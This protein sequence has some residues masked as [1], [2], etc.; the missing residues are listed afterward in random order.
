MEGL[1]LSVEAGWAVGLLLAVT[2]VAAFAVAS[3]VLSHALP[4]PGRVA[5]VLAI[6]WFLAEPVS[7][8]LTLEELL[9]AGVTNAVI[10]GALG[11][12]TGALFHMFATAGGIIDFVSGLAIAQVL[13]PNQGTRASVF[14]R[15]FGLSGLAMFYVTGGLQLVAG[16]LTLSVRALPLDGSISANP[17]L[18]QL[19]ADHTG[20]LLLAATELALPVL[21]AL[22]LVEVVLGIASRFAPQANVFL[23][24]L[25]AKLFVALSTVTVATLLFPEA[26]SGATDSMQRTFVAVLAGLGAG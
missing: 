26:M 8:D 23:L 13:D 12:L 1:N 19:S 7:P 22:F 25:P 16:G 2:R 18:A 17:D 20:R 5:A 11:F 15:L 14:G 3:P 24:G 4:L 21:A 9:A 6:G 10:G